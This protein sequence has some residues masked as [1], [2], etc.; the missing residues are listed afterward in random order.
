MTTR[1]DGVL[2]P[3]LFHPSARLS[4]ELSRLCSNA[5]PRCRSNG[6]PLLREGLSV[7]CTLQR[8]A[9]SDL[10][11]GAVKDAREKFGL[12]KDRRDVM[13]HCQ[14]VHENQLDLMQ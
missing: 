8:D 14:T 13:I 10:M 7:H 4:F 11:I 3:A 5:G 6:C 1:K 12:G 9:A 2:E